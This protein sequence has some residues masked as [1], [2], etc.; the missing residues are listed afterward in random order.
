MRSNKS[1]R[2]MTNAKFMRKL[3]REKTEEV[4]NE[5]V[6]EGKKEKVFVNE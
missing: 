1:E 3:K 2:R 5:S 6:D 4:I